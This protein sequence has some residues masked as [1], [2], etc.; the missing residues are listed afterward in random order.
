MK[1]LFN[2]IANKFVSRQQFNFEEGSRRAEVKYKR[3]LIGKSVSCTLTDTGPFVSIETT[4]E[5][6]G[7]L[8]KQEVEGIKDAAK[9]YCQTGKI[10]KPL[11]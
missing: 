7:T 9:T 8:S 3:V 4:Y 1:K 6:A 11:G 2:A 10:V 5:R